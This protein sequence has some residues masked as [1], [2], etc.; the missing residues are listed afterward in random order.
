[1]IVPG[2]TELTRMP[3]GP[4]SIAACETMVRS[5]AFEAEYVR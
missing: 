3:R 4:S 2:L 1:M 5:G